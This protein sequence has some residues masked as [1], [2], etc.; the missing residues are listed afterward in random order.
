L[1]RGRSSS[2]KPERAR[3]GRRFAVALLAALVCAAPAA[4]LAKTSRIHGVVLA[5]TPQDGQA[6]VRH[7]PFD[8]MPSMA[9]PFRIVP[10]ARAAELL[11]G[12]VIDAT[13]DTSTEPWTL[14]DIT[15]ATTQAVAA[16][17]RVA[18]LR[19]GDTVPDQPF[20]DQ[21]GRPFRFSML[22]GQD[23][24]LAFIYTRC[25]DPTMCPLISSHFNVLQREMGSRKLHLV[26]VTLDPSYDRPPVLARYARLFGADPKDWTLAVGDAQPTL[27]FAARFGIAV[28]PDPGAGIIHSE[29]TV[30]IGPDG[31]IRTM[32]PDAS[33]QPDQILADIDASRAAGADPFARIAFELAHGGIGGATAGAFAVL[34]AA[35]YLAFRLG[36][37]LTANR[38]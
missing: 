27:D 28:F 4:A 15:I 8:G 6:I 32:I 30:E 2:K 7:D 24:V 33:W 10:R 1:R 25:Q 23:V 35:G 29:N 13:A 37:R 21:A 17:A 26:E 5:V 14:R 19:L 9:M 20:V 11:P 36:R 3:F 34:A 12:N 22:R 38:A 18:P 31:T 16:P